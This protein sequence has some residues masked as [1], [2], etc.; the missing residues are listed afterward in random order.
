MGE[1][2]DGDKGD[3]KDWG[4]DWGKDWSMDG[5]KGDDKDWGKDWGKDRGKDWGKDRGKDW[6]TKPPKPPILPRSDPGSAPLQRLPTNS[7]APRPGSSERPGEPTVP[8]W[9]INNSWFQG[10]RS[11]EVGGL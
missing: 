9:S 10:R 3:D 7:H 6:G 1:S 8:L 4:K 5:D 2:M 11:S